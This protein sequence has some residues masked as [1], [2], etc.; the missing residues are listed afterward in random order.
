MGQYHGEYLRKL[1]LKLSRDLYLLSYLIEKKY[2]EKK[3]L[4]DC[5]KQNVQANC[6]AGLE[7]IERD[8]L[9][10]VS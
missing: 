4:F 3:K 6:F 5:V 2:I 7:A 8:F 1:V 9:A 10:R